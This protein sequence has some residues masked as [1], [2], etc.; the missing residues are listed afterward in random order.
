MGNGTVEPTNVRGG[1]V[2]WAWGVWSGA[3]G[4]IKGTVRLGRTVR[5]GFV[6]PREV[7]P[8]L[9]TRGEGRCFRPSGLTGTYH[10]TLDGSFFFPPSLAPHHFPPPPP[11]HP[12][13][14]FFFFSP[15]PPPPPSTPLPCFFPPPLSPP[16]RGFFFFPPPPPPFLFLPPP[17]FFFSPPPLFPTTFSPPCFFPLGGFF[18]LF[19]PPPQPTVSPPPPPFFAAGASGA[20]RLRLVG[21]GGAWVA[22]GVGGMYRPQESRWRWGRPGQLSVVETSCGARVLGPMPSGGDG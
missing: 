3:D 15:P 19:V 9:Q 8:S 17:P 21:S 10:G 2:G 20:A 14:L 5:S 16:P 18:I 6:L 7:F 12:P 13:F 11:V 4:C 1:L 22:G